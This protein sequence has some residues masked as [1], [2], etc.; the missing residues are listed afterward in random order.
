VSWTRCAELARERLEQGWRDRE[1][2]M[3]DLHELS[4][5]GLATRRSGS[6]T[7]TE[8]SSSCGTA[9]PR[10][11]NRALGRPRWPAFPTKPAT[12]ASVKVN[13]TTGRE[14]SKRPRFVFGSST[15]VERH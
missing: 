7:P 12:V 8:Q 2:D 11:V 5:T 14:A 1:L 15:R 6:A 10:R 3:S 4:Q 13:V 9:L